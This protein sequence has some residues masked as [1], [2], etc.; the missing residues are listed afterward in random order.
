MKKTI[1]IIILAVY[2][3]SIA[4]VNFF[5]LEVKPYDG[6]TYVSSIECQTITSLGN[7]SQKVYPSQYIGV[8]NDIPLFIFD[9]IPAKDGED[10]TRE[11]ESIALHPN[12]VQIDYEIL[13]HLA[14][15]AGVRFEFDENAGVAAFHELSSSFVFLKSNKPL[16]VTI[17]ATDGSNVSTVIAI[18]GRVAN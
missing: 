6:N 3:A 16:T 18:M 8:N 13:P 4:M 2:A 7:N 14:D 11:E 12:I 5:G 17:K 1:I 10:Y 9:F 15:E